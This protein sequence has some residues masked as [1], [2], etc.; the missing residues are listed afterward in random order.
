[1]LLYITAEDVF[2]DAAPERRRPRAPEGLPATL[3][4]LYDRGM[5]HHQ[6]PFALLGAEK[7]ELEGTPDWKL[8]RL[9]IRI[10]LYCR[11][12]MGLEPG[13]RAAVFGPLGWLWPAAEFAIQGFSAVSVG[14]EHDL[15]EAALVGALRDAQPRVIFATDGASAARI[16]ELRAQGLLTETTLVVED[17]G[18]PSGEVFPLGQLLQ[19][20][21]TLDTAERAQAFRM[22]CRGARPESEALWHVHA[23]GIERLTH[24]QGMERV[25]ARLRSRPPAVG[26]VVYLQPPRVTLDGRL[27]LATFL[28]DGLTEAVLARDGAATDEVAGLRPHGMRVAAEWLEA[29]CRGRGPRW[30]GGLDRRRARR[31][32]QTVLG[33][34]LRWVET[35]RPVDGSTVAALAAVGVTASGEGESESRCARV[36]GGDDGVVAPATG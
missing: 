20:G 12:K 29:T 24:A 36:R 25:A 11:E 3:S 19:L 22:M 14:I 23:G 21:G 2:G 33:N 10:A 18:S 34:R 32:L 27:A 15:E 16:L 9:V 31:R 28:G 1:M 35:E 5:R 17:A 30:P 6:R 8:D 13:T 26:D 4:A 7:D